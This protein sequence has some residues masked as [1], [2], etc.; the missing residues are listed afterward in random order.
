MDKLVWNS[1]WLVGVEDVDNKHIGFL[2]LINEMTDL[3]KDVNSISHNTSQCEQSA[4]NYCAKMKDITWIVDGFLIPLLDK[5]MSDVQHC[6]K[7]IEQRVKNNIGQR[8]SQY[9]S[10]YNM[11]MT[12]LLHY[13]HHY[14]AK[15]YA[16]EE[17]IDDLQNWFVTH[18][19]CTKMFVTIWGAQT[20]SSL[21]KRA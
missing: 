3:V 6:F 7:D 19:E 13:I 4:C 20:H 14:Q 15:D 8:Y 21:L 10:N 1:D 2:R 9:K 12:E 5:L 17:F 16:K 11:L 18:M